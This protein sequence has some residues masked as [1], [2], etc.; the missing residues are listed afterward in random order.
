M[1]SRIR[2]LFPILI[3][4]LLFTL[5]MAP[6]RQSSPPSP[7]L[8]NQLFGLLIAFLTSWQLKTLLGLIIVDVALGVA[9]ALRR[10]VFDWARLADFYKTAVLP[11]VIGYL[12]FYVAIGFLIPPES[13]GQLGEPVNQATVTLAWGALVANLI[14]SILGNFRELYQ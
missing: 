13:L 1:K 6:P 2:P 11:Y 3:M 9:S 8:I 14:K 4:A 7:D 10:N 5:G 12:A